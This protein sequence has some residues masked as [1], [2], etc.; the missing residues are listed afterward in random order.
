[1]QSTGFIGITEILW[2]DGSG[3]DWRPHELEKSHLA[4][5]I[6]H[7]TNAPGNYST[8]MFDGMVVEAGKRGM[9]DEYLAKAPYPYIDAETGV[10]M[11]AVYSNGFMKPK[12]YD[13]ISSPASTQAILVLAIGSSVQ[14]ITL[15]PTVFGDPVWKSDLPKT[16]KEAKYSANDIIPWSHD[17]GAAVMTYWLQFS[18]ATADNIEW[19]E[20]NYVLLKVFQKNKFNITHLIVQDADL[21]PCDPVEQICS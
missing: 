19:R 16:T 11:I 3:R 4:N 20:K 18:G 6:Y 10:K 15:D 5:I 17:V 8:S 1:M 21:R 7:I 13:D 12:P 9:T 2:R 14:G